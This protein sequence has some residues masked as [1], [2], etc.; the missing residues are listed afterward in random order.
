MT[1]GNVEGCSHETEPCPTV[2]TPIDRFYV[3]RMYTLPHAHAQTSAATLS[4][5]AHLAS[6]R[7]YPLSS[8]AVANVRS[9]PIGL[10]AHADVRTPQIPSRLARSRVCMPASIASAE[11]TTWR[12]RC[13]SR[14]VVLPRLNRSTSVRRMCVRSGIY[15]A[16]ARPFPLPHGPCDQRTS[17]SRPCIGGGACVLQTHMRPERVRQ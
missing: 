13:A 7:S 15:P 16:P 2:C 5:R 8:R 12:A 4:A 1:C 10:R 3:H 17:R 9:Y 6:V 14:G 11:L